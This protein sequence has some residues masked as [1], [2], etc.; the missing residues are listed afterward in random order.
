MVRL[1]MVIDSE[2]IKSA[3][4]AA[5][6]NEVLCPKFGRTPQAIWL[7]TRNGVPP[8]PARFLHEM[9]GVPLE[10]LSPKHYADEPLKHSQ[11]EAA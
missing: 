4:K 5:G 8:R 1:G 7:W 3:I 11:H 10:V 2:A 9:S 6:G